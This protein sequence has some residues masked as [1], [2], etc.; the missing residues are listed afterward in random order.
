M[1]GVATVF[2]P[3][4]AGGIMVP[5]PDILIGSFNIGAPDGT[6]ALGGTLPVGT[7]SGVMF[8]LQ[9]W[10]VP[11]GFATQFAATTAIQATTP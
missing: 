8:W 9:A 10:F 2:A 11:T 3:F 5:R 6:Q 4:E 7:P 1:L